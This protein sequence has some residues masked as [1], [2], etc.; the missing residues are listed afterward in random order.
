MTERYT[1]TVNDIKEM[2]D[3]V[4]LP[5]SAKRT[6]PVSPKRTVAKLEVRFADIKMV[7]SGVS[8]TALR[9]GVS[10]SRKIKCAGEG[11]L[12]SFNSADWI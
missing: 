12:T 5:F 2:S 6:S 8:R 10:K 1:I 7:R 11:Q 4:S 3:L 9:G